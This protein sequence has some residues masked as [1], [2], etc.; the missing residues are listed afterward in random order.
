MLDT[1]DPMEAQAKRSALSALLHAKPLSERIL[2]SASLIAARSMTIISVLAYLIAA[3]RN[4]G[5]H[6]SLILF[7]CA[8]VLLLA[9]IS[10]RRRRL[11]GYQRLTILSVLMI[12]MAIAAYLRNGNL[13]AALFST[14]PVAIFLIATYGVRVAM[15]LTVSLHIF[16]FFLAILLGQQDIATILIYLSISFFW[17]WLGAIFV[18]L[19]LVQIDADLMRINTLLENQSR[20]MNVISHELRVPSMTLSALTKRETYSAGDRVTMREAADQLVLVIDHLR[21]SV[22]TYDLRPISKD[23]VSMDKFIAQL[24][25]EFEPILIDLGFTLYTDTYG[26]DGALLVVDRFRL[27]AVI[28]NFL[29]S[30]AYN[31]DGNRIWLNARTKPSSRSGLMQCI[32]EIDDNGSAISGQRARAMW[33]AAKSSDLS[34]SS[35]GQGLWL[36]QTWLADMG[37]DVDYYSSPRGG[38]GFR[39]TLNVE[40]ST[41]ANPDAVDLLSPWDGM[42]VLLTAQDHALRP[43]IERQLNLIGMFVDD[44]SSVAA[45]AEM[46]TKG[47]YDLQIYDMD[48]AEGE[49]AEWLELTRHT[50]R[51]LPAI[52]MSSSMHNDVKAR[53]MDT[54]AV[55]V[56]DKPIHPSDFVAALQSLATLGSL[57]RRV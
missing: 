7:Q 23:Y 13:L 51:R 8:I 41:A 47:A 50:N 14:L 3:P 44:A 57:Q 9:L 45:A 38:A 19:L 36:T 28:S 56:L 39:M 37:G 10:S 34:V 26:S 49:V 48:I 52:I 32:I 6:N 27:R 16:F 17:S 35:M 24:G 25:V 1:S 46:L 43:M 29:R 54:G 18:G 2:A 30:A 42:R 12:V 15:F 53:L 21:S 33:A 31:S 4:W 22:E 11:S 55:V 5:S 20:L 40:A